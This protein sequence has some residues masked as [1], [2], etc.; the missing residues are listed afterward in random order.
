MEAMRK[1]IAAKV[2]KMAVNTENQ[3]PF[4]ESTILKAMDKLKFSV[5]TQGK[6]DMVKVQAQQVIKQCEDRKILPIERAKIRVRV[7]CPS[8]EAKESFQK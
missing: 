3:K 4:P 2:V 5:Q 6:K 7:E 8:S 1:K